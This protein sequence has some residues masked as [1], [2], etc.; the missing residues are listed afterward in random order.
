MTSTDGHSESSDDG[1]G[2][3]EEA[4]E[5]AE[6]LATPGSQHVSAAPDSA[7]PNQHSEANKQGTHQD[8]PAEEFGAF[9]DEGWS[10][11]PLALSPA[12]SSEAG[13][14]RPDKVQAFPSGGVL[15]SEARAGQDPAG[16]EAKVDLLDLPPDKFTLVVNRLLQ[17]SNFFTPVVQP[18]EP[19][20]SQSH[21]PSSEHHPSPATAVCNPQS[22]R[23]KLMRLWEAQGIEAPLGSA[24]HPECLRS[25]LATVVSLNTL[26]HLVL[27]QLA[28][29]T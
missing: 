19:A 23:A 9:E 26:Q 7:D 25:G 10:S 4:P 17:P 20:A 29:G 24:L 11:A 28:I 15:P 6:S 16:V 5:P 18:T 1:F 13:G 12:E 2:T 8:E 14:A 21:M 27:K 22:G 3:F